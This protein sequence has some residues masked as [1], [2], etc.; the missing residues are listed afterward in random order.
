MRTVLKYPGAKNRLAKWICGYIP[1]HDVYLEPYFGGG[2]IFF[3]KEP[4][5]IETIND[6]DGNV[7][8]FFKV[9]RD[10]QAELIRGLKLTP[11][12]RE[13]Y[14]AAFNDEGDSDVERARKFCVRC[15]QGFG[16]SNVYRNGFRSSQQSTSPDTTKIWDE[17]LTTLEWAAFRI[18]DAQIECLDALELIGRYDTKD[19]FIYADPP[20]LTTVRKQY[21]YKHEMTEEEHIAMLEKLLAHP[22]KVMISG[23][24]S[25]LYEEYLKGWNKACKDTQAEFGLKR[26]EVLWMNY[27]L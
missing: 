13:E 15:W 8:N 5:R 27:R 4:C 14:E 22:G 21:L 9:L 3:N 17:L 10:N 24:E 20:Y 6:L 23:Y 26:K 16:C 1:Q 2:A 25:E 19:V 7:V 12:A 11:Y 18:K